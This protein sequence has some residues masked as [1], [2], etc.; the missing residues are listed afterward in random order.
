MTHEV[1]SLNEECGILG[2][3][4]TQMLQ[5]DLFRITQSST[6]WSEGARILSNDAGQLRTVSWYG[7]SLKYF[8]I[9]LAW[10]S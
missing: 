8:V 5:N 2:S 7:S 4:D 6:P 1:K 9:L 3:G 10:I